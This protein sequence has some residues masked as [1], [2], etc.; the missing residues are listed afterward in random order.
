MDSEVKKKQL[1]SHRTWMLAV[2]ALSPCFMPPILRL[3]QQPAKHRLF[4][5]PVC[6]D[7]TAVEDPLLES[8]CSFDHMPLLVALKSGDFLEAD[9]STRQS[10]IKLAG[11]DAIGR[12]FVYFAEVPRLPQEDLATIERLWLAYSGGKFGYSVQ[13]GIFGTKMVGRDLDHF[14]ERI[15]WKN[16]RGQLLR[17]LPDKGNEFN[18]D[19]E[20]APKG[21]L[22]LTSTL[23]GTQLLLGLLDH[24][25]WDRSEFSS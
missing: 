6:F 8:A 25:T 20:K 16:D 19:L 22:P 14:Y 1:E 4:A 10:L 18:Y 11:E 17:W 15:G 13:K 21:H 24:A 2:L 7:A 23:R 9:R 3:V 12:G 5:S